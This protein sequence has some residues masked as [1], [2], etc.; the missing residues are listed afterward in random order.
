VLELAASSA[1]GKLSILWIEQDGVAF[2]IRSVVGDVDGGTFGAARLLDEGRVALMNVRGHVGVSSSPDGTF[3]GIYRGRERAC[4]EGG[5]AR[6][7]GFGVRPL[8]AR[9]AGEGR[10]PLAVPRPCRR[11]VAGIASLGDRFYY[12]VCAEAD[13]GD[14]TTVYTIQL[15]PQ[16]ARSDRVLVGCEPLGSTV[17]DGGVWVVGQCGDTRRIAR[18][19]P[20]HE[21][22]SEVALTGGAVR[23]DGD[24]PVLPIADGVEVALT[25][26]MDRLES[27]LPPALAEGYARAVWTGESL[28]LAVS[29]GHD[30][31][32]HR[33]ECERGDFMR[34]DVL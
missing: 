17:I 26:P 13:E 2:P 8:S 31:A 1:G 28:L 7:V 32:V 22:A 19:E 25:G 11:A 4:E 21:R 30:V 23:C 24:R 18:F 15:E 14:A 10:V 20:G 9:M 12:G 33:Y 34:T 16:Y 29:L 3:V 5:A 27:L 6:C